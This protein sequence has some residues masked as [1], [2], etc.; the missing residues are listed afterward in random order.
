MISYNQWLD[1]ATAYVRVIAEDR[2]WWLKLVINCQTGSRYLKLSHVD[3]K[4]CRVRLSDHRSMAIGGQQRVF[5]VRRVATLRLGELEAFLA[6]VPFRGVG[7][8]GWGPRI[9][10][11]R[12]G[13]VP[14][15]SRGAGRPR[16]ESGQPFV[17]NVD[18]ARGSE[19]P[20]VLTGGLS[21]HLG[22]H[23]PLPIAQATK[24][25][26]WQTEFLNP[27]E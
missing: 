8:R 1:L 23:I 16:F 4:G 25:D 11:E 21:H 7:V 12:P 24:I 14:A 18:E 15:C 2:G 26:P 17:T 19:S 13:V 20:P 3:R 22:Q 10:T 5:S 6:L 27:N 9:Q